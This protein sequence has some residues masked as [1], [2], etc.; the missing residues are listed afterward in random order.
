MM[1]R[2]LS[3]VTAGL[4]LIAA[5]CQ[6][7]AVPTA[8]LTLPAQT[9]AAA[10][11]AA[12]TEAVIAVEA[13]VARQTSAA[14]EASQTR[15]AGMAATATARAERVAAT[16][17]AEKLAATAQAATMLDA[18]VG[19]YGQGYLTRTE[20]EYYLLPEFDETWAQ[21]DWYQWTY[22]DFSPTDFVIRGHAAWDSASDTAN[23][24]NSGCGFVFREKDVDN[25]YLAYLALD[26][27]VYLSRHVRGV[28]ADLGSSFYG[29]LD[30]PTG[31]ANLMLAADGP[32]ITFFVNGD[33]IH[34]RQ[35]S[36]LASGN[37]ALT[38]I[39]G[40]NKGYGTRCHLTELE[41]WILR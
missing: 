12:A 31:E 5:A 2:W 26:G 6:P 13:T 37:L 23:W 9:A 10:T 4:P 22:T 18:V 24:F 40:T 21:I 29:N 17:E 14:A 27:W 28:Y 36:G 38:L 15:V 11:Q 30:V 39:S 35:D 41:L 20:G 32:D 7:R 3:V 1:T 19:L 8:D 33:P 34:S 16:R 25:H